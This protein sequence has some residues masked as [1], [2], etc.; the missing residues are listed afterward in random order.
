MKRG[1]KQNAEAP[2]AAA[3]TAAVRV[4]VTAVVAAGAAAVV[5]AAVIEEIVATEAIVAI[6]G[7]SAQVQDSQLSDPAGTAMGS[8]Q[9]STV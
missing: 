8:A 5:G 2:A 4:G 9:V 3:A 1:P 7:R 6:A